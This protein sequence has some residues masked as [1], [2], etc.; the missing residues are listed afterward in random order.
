MP[1][2]RDPP[3]IMRF[4]KMGRSGGL[5]G[6]PLQLMIVILVA[7]MGTAIIL[8]WMGNIETPHSIG[9]ISVEGSDG[10]TVISDD[11]VL[12]DFTVT[13]RDQ[14]GEHLEGATVVLKGL[15]V[16]DAEGGTAYAVTGPNGKATFS[17]LRIDPAGHGTTGF[18]TLI[19]SMPGYGESSS[20]KVAVI[21]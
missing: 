13:V 2:L 17:G 19:V 6:L 18:I 5:E 12:R 3:D 8:G 21:L 7:T 16:T 15:N 20:T 10:S 11:G 14:D 1:A 4:D 9:E